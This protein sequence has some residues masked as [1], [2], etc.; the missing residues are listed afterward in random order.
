MIEGA[1]KGTRGRILVVDDEAG[2]RRL[3]HT[4]LRDEGFDVEEAE[5]G[6]PGYPFAAN[7]LQWDKF[8]SIISSRR[9]RPNSSTRVR[10][11]SLTP[12]DKDE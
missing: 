7:Y 8:R 10:P 5:S 12:E 6:V 9:G 11:V 3:V 4:Q 2:S 1:N